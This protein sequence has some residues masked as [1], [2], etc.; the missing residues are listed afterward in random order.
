L[1]SSSIVSCIVNFFFKIYGL[2]LQT[3]MFFGIHFR[4]TFVNEHGTIQDQQSYMR[5]KSISK[6]VLC[7]SVII[8][9]RESGRHTRRFTSYFLYT[10][11]CFD[12]RKCINVKNSDILHLNQ[13][14]ILNVHRFMQTSTYSH[15]FAISACTCT[16]ICK[17]FSC[18]SI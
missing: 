8:L 13:R 15:Y 9:F 1:I 2:S 17:R 6:L 3:E 14:F 12:S 10:C 16:C 5:D 18:W 11:W 7:R 4:Y